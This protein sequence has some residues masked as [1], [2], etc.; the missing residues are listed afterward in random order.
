MWVDLDF[1]CFD[2][3]DDAFGLIALSSNAYLQ[4]RVRAD[5]PLTWYNGTR[6]DLSRSVIAASE[7]TKSDAFTVYSD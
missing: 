7:V 2:N 4:A 5:T 6:Q 1:Y 3:S